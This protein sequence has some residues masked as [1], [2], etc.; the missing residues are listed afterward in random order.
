MFILSLGAL[1]A[2]TWSGV[3]PVAM[4]G[5][6][7]AGETNMTPPTGA[8]GIL[9]A[10]QFGVIVATGPTVRRLVQRVRVWHG[11][12]AFS[13]VIMTVYL[14]HLTA[15][16]L[17]AAGGLFAFDGWAFR[18]EPGTWTWWM[19]RPVWLLVLS[20]LTVLLVIAFARFE[21]RISDAPTP[22]SRRIVTIGVLLVAGSAGA[23]AGIGITTP[24][25]VVQ[26]SI[27]AAAIA[28]AAMLGALPRL[29]RRR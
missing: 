17:A 1:V 12:V 18:V 19:T 25:A 5:V 23:V 24:D 16:S 4:V 20:A 2:L 21:W 8:L 26:W 7:G 22:T 14:W 6:P 28:G 15:M 10:M 29:G 13:G 27:P 9:G 3:Y 11:V